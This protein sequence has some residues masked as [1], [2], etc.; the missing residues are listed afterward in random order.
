MTEQ[1]QADPDHGDPLTS[2]EDQPGW[3]REAVEEFDEYGL[4][5]Y[6]LPR[7]SDGVY[8]HEIVGELE[9]N[10]DINI[11]FIGMDVREGDPWETQVDGR[12]VG[13]VHRHRHQDGYSVVE[14]ESSDFEEWLRTAVDDTEDG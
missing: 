12:T 9:D 14:I 6:R 13:E 2:G 3:L 1:G 10:Y 8:L 7:F 5:P 4:K 11:R